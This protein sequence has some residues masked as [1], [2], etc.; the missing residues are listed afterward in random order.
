MAEAE[1]RKTHLHVQASGITTGE[2]RAIKIPDEYL[3]YSKVSFLYRHDEYSTRIYDVFH[4]NLS[5]GAGPHI[6]ATGHGVKPLWIEDLLREIA[7]K[8]GGK[9]VSAK[10]YYQNIYE[11]TI[12]SREPWT[13]EG[14]A[15]VVDEVY[16]PP[17]FNVR[18]M[19]VLFHNA[20]EMDLGIPQEKLKFTNE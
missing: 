17:N 14:L 11:G 1:T 16:A 9:F 7:Q 8:T 4:S 18:F 5:D 2:L 20:P 6:K 12:S 3:S 13:K 15:R 19:S 10:Q